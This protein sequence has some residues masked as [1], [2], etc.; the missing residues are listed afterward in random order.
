MSAPT[1]PELRNALAAL[2]GEANLYADP[3][4]KARYETGARYG[5]GKAALIV[6]PASTAEVAAVVRHCVATA[7][8]LIA[9]GAN[10]G[11]V[12]ASTP[13]ESGTQVV[14]SLERLRSELVIDRANRTATVGA[15]VTLQELN[16]KLAEHGLCFP[17]DLGANPSIGGMI[18]TNTGGA[19]LIRYG[20]VRHN[21]LGVEVVLAD[22][23][24]QVLDLMS[25]LR[26]NNT[27]YDLKQLFV[28][29]GGAGGVITRAVVQVHPLPR[30]T[31][32][33]LIV[34]TTQQAT[35]DLLIELESEFGDF[36]TA[37]EGMS[38]STVQSVID[39]VPG[40]ANPFAPEPIPDYCL[41]VELAATSSREV[42]GVDLQG[43]LN[44][45]LER[46]FDVLV[47]NAVLDGGPDLWK[48]RHSI[49]ESIRHQGKLIAFDIA[50]PRSSMIAF[51]ET[52]QRMLDQG[53]PW[54]RLF[55]FGHWA[56]GGTHFNIVWPHDATPAYDADTVE[57]LRVALYDLVVRDFGGS[58]SAEHGVGP[59]NARFY[60]RYASA[61]SQALAG[62]VQRALDPARALGQVDF[63]PV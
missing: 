13:D 45:F 4:D 54:L 40:V 12:A 44:D 59:Y 47:S 16:D 1:D 21:L 42:L 22:P 50:V 41:L 17:I 31:A 19:R 26:K 33:A 7:T 15:G 46:Q 58:F 5:N 3:A 23:P 52:A 20:D 10:T 48:I 60:H 25:G 43:A 57:R 35:L 61:E 9:Q 24:G 39:H 38:R 11:L 53:F 8:P 37:Y 2:V 36:L 55:D 27:G 28:G 32:T 62:R 30:Q 29:V 34:P 14:L 63:G 51:R 6:R 49:S 56:D 18:A